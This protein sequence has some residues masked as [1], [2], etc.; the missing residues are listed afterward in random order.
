MTTLQ[1][2]GGLAKAAAYTLSTAGTAKK[3]QALEAIAQILTERQA[4]WLSANA[5]DVAAAKEAGMRSAMLDRLTLTPSRIAGI[6]DSIL[7]V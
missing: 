5:E 7:Q 4:E 6:V 1:T 3:N 2:Q